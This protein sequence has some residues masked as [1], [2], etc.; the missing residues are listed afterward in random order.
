[1]LIGTRLFFFLFSFLFVGFLFLALPD[2]G[3]SGLAQP[4]PE[5]CQVEPDQCF[6]FGDGNG[7]E[8]V[9]V[10]RVD[11]LQPGFCNEQTGMCELTR[12]NPIPTLGEWGML[13][14]VAALGIV[15]YVY[16]RRRRA[17]A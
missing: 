7:D 16:Y 11:N 13:I 1:M 5:C 12:T 10:C 4:G 15:G 3:F 17:S 8:P 2:E 14:T 9:P 6:D